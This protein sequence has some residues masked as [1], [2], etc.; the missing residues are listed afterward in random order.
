M[1]EELQKKLHSA[2]GLVELAF[3]HAVPIMAELDIRFD[4]RVDTACVCPS[5]RMLVGP[6]FAEKLTVQHLAF[7]VA[8]EL[9]H[10]LYGV[11]DRF[12]ENTSPDRRWLINVAHDFL[13]NDMVRETL[14]AFGGDVYIPA[15]GLFWEEYGPVYSNFLHAQPPLSQFTLESLVLELERLR[16]YLPHENML[17]AMANGQGEGGA[18]A[19]EK[20][21]QTGGS[22]SLEPPLG[23]FPSDAF[24]GLSPEDFPKGED[25]PQAESDEESS[26]GKASDQEDAAAKARELSELLN[27]R[28]I[29]ELVSK[30]LERELFPDEPEVERR[31]RREEVQRGL[32]GMAA[33]KELGKVFDHDKGPGAGSGDELV[34]ALEGH[35][36]TPWESVLQKWLDDSAPPVRSWAH[37][38]RRAGDRTDVVLPG[39][40]K[41]GNMINIVLDTSGSMNELLPAALGMIQSFGR[42]SGVRC[43]HVVQCDSDVTSDEMVDL[44]ELSKHEIK[45]VTGGGMDPPGMLRMAEDPSVESVLVITDGDID[46]PPPEAVPYEVLW[47]VVC[48]GGDTSHFQ[49][50]YG[51]VVGVPIEDLPVQVE[52]Y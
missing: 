23:G 17:D 5:G 38:S 47:W 9:Y 41:D 33:Q 42:S 35:Y 8:H 39:R 50:P 24:D 13:V 30:E 43:A 15:E 6:A 40:R 12:D 34:S 44:E 18:Q 29:P 11:F 28:R 16:D 31:H 20:S 52:D 21:P 7:V 51:R 46:I 36:D 4:D 1:T 19:G 37:A 22:G 25:Q 48:R 14:L 26:A 3:P 49:P 32:E 27:R 45:Q 2:M 10:I